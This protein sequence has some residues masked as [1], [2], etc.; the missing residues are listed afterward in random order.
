[1][2][3]T[4]TIVDFVARTEQLPREVAAKATHHILDCTGCAI[5]GSVAEAGRM[6]LDYAYKYGGEGAAGIFGSKGGFSPEDAAFVNGVYSHAL[7]YDDTSWTMIGHPSAVVLPAALAVGEEV[8]ASGTELLAAYAIGVEVACKLGAG[9]VPAHYDIGWHSTSTLGTMGA[10]AAAAKLLGLEPDKMRRAFGIAASQACGLMRNFGSM[11]KPYHAGHAARNGVQAA[12]MAEAGFTASI[13]IM[14]G[15]RGFCDIFTPG[16]SVDEE[17]IVSRLG[18]PYDL[19]LPGIDIKFY[20]TCAFTHCAIDAM[21]ALRHEHGFSAHDIETIECRTSPLALKVLQHSR[22]KTAL[23]G[24]FSMEF[25]LAAGALDGEVG[26]DQLADKRV[27]SQDAQMMIERVGVVADDAMAAQGGGR[28]S[29]SVVTL[30]LKNGSAVSKRVELPK[31]CPD[32]P[33][34]LEEIGHKFN[35]CASKLLEKSKLAEIKERVLDLEK[36]ADLAD[37]TKAMR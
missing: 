7:D 1:M 19:V 27:A 10:C 34:S 6:A 11:T 12:L 37:L 22:P 16:G 26:L 13:D 4:D 25:C 29:P 15:Q 18:S 8:G 33:L 30:K 5:A 9:M 14:D 21:L 28:H 36:I 3:I 17:K 35:Q 23:Q 31:G 24:K 20:P 32:N 2:N